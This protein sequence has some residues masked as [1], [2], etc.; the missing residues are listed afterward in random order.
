[1]RCSNEFDPRSTSARRS[2]NVRIV[3]MLVKA[4]SLMSA[5]VQ[6]CCRSHDSASPMPS[7]SRRLKRV[8]RNT[9]S[10]INSIFLAKTRRSHLS[11]RPSAVIH[12]SDRAVIPP[13]DSKSPSSR[14]ARRDPVVG[15]HR[16]PAPRVVHRLEIVSGGK[17]LMSMQSRYTGTHARDFSSRSALLA[18]RR[19]PDGGPAKGSAE[20]D[21]RSRAINEHSV[22]GRNVIDALTRNR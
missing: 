11:M 19:S 14:G 3:G 21:D 17:R 15:D 22:C 7:R 16:S 12:K 8:G 18:R 9:G 1:M 20:N 5:F 4:H 2:L 10:R 6:C 13:S